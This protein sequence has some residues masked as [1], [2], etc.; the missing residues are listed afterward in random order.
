MNINEAKMVEIDRNRVPV[1]V[2]INENGEILNDFRKNP[3]CNGCKCHLNELHIYKTKEAAERALEKWIN[4]LKTVSNNWHN[5][6]LLANTCKWRNHC[7]AESEKY[8]KLSESLK[9]C[10]IE[11]RYLIKL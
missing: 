10:K 7:L 8:A 9:K 11:K 3:Y 4:H 6:H 1:Y 2:I 5:D